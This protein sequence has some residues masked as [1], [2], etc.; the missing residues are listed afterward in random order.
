MV[1]RISSIWPISA[2]NIATPSAHL[3]R[4]AVLEATFV[5]ASLSC[6]ESSCKRWRAGL[7]WEGLCFFLFFFCR[8]F[9]ELTVSGWIIL[10]QSHQIHPQNICRVSS[11]F[12]GGMVVPLGWW[13]APN[14]GPTP[15]I[16]RVF[17]AFSLWF[18]PSYGLPHSSLPRKHDQVF[19]DGLASTVGSERTV[20][21]RR[22]DVY[23]GMASLPGCQ[24]SRG[25]NLVGDGCRC[26]RRS[27]NCWF[28]CCLIGDSIKSSQVVNSPNAIGCSWSMFIL[29]C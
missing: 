12:S 6:L 25:W 16:P 18:Y 13:K 24:W 11:Y 3:L 22:R 28:M 27:P 29:P 19:R 10:K 7:S 1:S 15:S 8:E 26:P 5:Q 4:V 2:S 23:I 21:S 9:L 14:S 17:P 20:G